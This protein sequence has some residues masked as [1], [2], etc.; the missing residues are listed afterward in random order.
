MAVGAAA[1][2][3]DQPISIYEVHLPSWRRVPEEANR[4]LTFFEV[5]PLLAEHA[6]L[7]NFT[8]IQLHAP[9]FT[10]PAGLRFLIDYLHKQ[11]LCVI[12]DNGQYFEAQ[13]PDLEETRLDGICINSETHMYGYDY[14][15]DLAWAED[16]AAYF[17]T[18]PL[19]RKY[20]QGLFRRRDGYA[21]DANHILSL[22]W[23]LV[24]H[25]RPSLFTIMPGDTWQKFSNLRLLYAYMYLLPGKKQL[26]MGA[27]FG[28]QNRWQPETSL[29]WH[30]LD[31]RGFHTRLMNWVAALN[32]FYREEQVLHETD[33]SPAGLQWIDTSDA[34]WSIISFLRQC[35]ATGELLL[36]VLNFTP[37][38]RHNYRV[39][40]PRDGFWT[41][42]LNSDAVEYGGSGQGNLGGLEAAPFGWNFQSHSLMLTLPPL[43]AIVLK[44]EL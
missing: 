39:G 28:Q 6:R 13:R 16:T 1:C 43:G 14:K 30:L 5:A 9:G 40:V 4:S 19:Y 8:H 17:A 41:E 10:D 2:A 34:S 27:E 23:R 38:P 15:L 20:H 11:G 24:N 7:L 32:R 22:S 35:P 3:P 21:F 29:D 37:L 44:A 18:D 33:F 31:G 36:A 12:L 26:F 42:T 25:P